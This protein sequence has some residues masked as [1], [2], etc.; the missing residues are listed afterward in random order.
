MDTLPCEIICQIISFL[1]IEQKVIC[2]RVSRRLRGII[3]AE[4]VKIR[5]IE[6]V[7][8]DRRDEDATFNSSFLF[9]SAETTR[10]AVTLHQ[11]SFFCFLFANCPRL[12]VLIAPSK[13]VH[14]KDISKFDMKLKYFSCKSIQLEQ[15]LKYVHFFPRLLAFDVE[16][17]LHPNVK[18]CHHFYYNAKFESSLWPFVQFKYPCSHGFNCGNKSVLPKNSRKIRSMSML[19]TFDWDVLLL[20]D[21]NQC[22]S[23]LEYLHL[24]NISFHRMPSLFFPNLKVLVVEKTVR[25]ELILDVLNFS[26]KLEEIK[27]DFLGESTVFTLLARFIG[28]S[29]HLKRLWL[30]LEIEAVEQVQIALPVQLVELTL[31]S[32]AQVEIVNFQLLTQIKY[33][34]INFELTFNLPELRDFRFSLLRNESYLKPVYSRRVTDSISNST[35]LKLLDVN[36]KFITHG[37]VER[38][39][40][41]LVDQFKS[42]TSFYLSAGQSDCVPG[43]KFQLDLSSRPN[44][45]SLFWNVQNA[46]LQVMLGDYFESLFLKEMSLGMSNELCNLSYEEEFYCLTSSCLCSF[47]F[48][49]PMTKL[50]RMKFQSVLQLER[51]LA[52]HLLPSVE[53]IQVIDCSVAHFTSPDRNTRPVHMDKLVAIVEHL[54]SIKSLKKVSGDAGFQSLCQPLRR[55]FNPPL[56]IVRTDPPSPPKIEKEVVEDARIS[57]WLVSPSYTL[58]I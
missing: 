9:R 3:Q 36:C 51:E 12:E 30:A 45:K 25:F 44:F 39:L 53:E 31:L 35:G 56:T 8:L 28:S 54:T 2:M 21:F 48:Q 29:A 24:S 14:W 4:L 11:S 34:N 5:S 40:Q 43:T 15:P 22:S 50:K 33:L 26:N 27:V 16:V 55:H 17:T 52:A 49:Q 7:D 41:L 42:V 37:E 58:K 1:T 57:T 38:I 47:T 19:P 32:E 6:V 10:V 13:N 46:K 23:S 18:M 20:S